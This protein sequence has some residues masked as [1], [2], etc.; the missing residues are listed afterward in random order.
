MIETIGIFNQRLIAFFANPRDDF[1]HA[2][3]DIQIILVIP[4]EQ[5]IQLIFKVRITAIKAR[6]RNTGLSL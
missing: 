4:G 6:Y 3:M 1:Q 5:G 2:L